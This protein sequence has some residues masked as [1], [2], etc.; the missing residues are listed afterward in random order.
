MCVKLI[1]TKKYQ[2]DGWY[3]SVIPAFGR[4]SMLEASLEYNSKFKAEL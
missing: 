1:K 3:M 2:Y 4:L